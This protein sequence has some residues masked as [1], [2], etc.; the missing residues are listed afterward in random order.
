MVVSRILP[1]MKLLTIT[2]AISPAQHPRNPRYANPAPSSQS[3]GP[4]RLLPH[5]LSLLY[6]MEPKSP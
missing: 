2:A 5:I 3:K 1:T 6:L 4:V